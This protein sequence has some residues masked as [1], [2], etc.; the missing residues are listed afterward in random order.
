MV[1]ARGRLLAAAAALLAVAAGCS[2]SSHSSSNGNAGK[3][4]TLGVLT[5]ITGLAKANAYTIPLGVKAG[6]GA[7]SSQGYHLKYVVADTGSSPTGALTAAKT[8]V[9]QDHVFAV[10]ANS[11]L[12]F[13]AAPYLE[14]H[15]IPV[16]GAAVD[17][18]EWIKD[19]NMFSVIGTQDYTK[20]F[21]NFG[22]FFKLVGV[23]NVASLGYSIS[24]SSSDS[25]K[26]AA[27]SAE[28]A[29]IKVGY[30]NANFPFGST[31]TGPEVLAMKSAGVNGFTGSIETSTGFALINDLRQNGVNLKAA[32]FATGYGGDLAQGGS[33]AERLAQGFYFLTSFE[34]LEMHTAATQRFH[35]ALVKYAS[36]N[37]DPTFAEYQG[38]LSVLAFVQGLKGAGASPTQASLI[39]SL[40]AIGSFTGDGLYGG[41]SVGFALDLR[42][43]ATGPDNCW[44]ITRYEGSSFHLV[45][46]ADPLCGSLVPGKTV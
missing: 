16:I 2:S 34:P 23:T 44:W 12:T 40:L 38:Y 33:N 14:S 32:L 41:H 26:G 6:I 46:H 1:H 25:A 5:D 20:V 37:G 8:L 28:N 17:A 29:G 4:Y 19:R 3:T 43:K 36:V 30:L 11:A 13:A 21:T 27:A 24:P 31:N 18:S 42:G 9:E 15:G 45:P 39:N 22:L 7:V 35:N 10:V